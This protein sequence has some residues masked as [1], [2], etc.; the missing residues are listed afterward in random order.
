MRT[1]SGCSGNNAPTAHC[2]S[3]RVGGTNGFWTAGDLGVLSGNPCGGFQL[4]VLAMIQNRLTVVLLPFLLIGLGGCTGSEESKRLE[5]DRDVR[6]LVKS[7]QEN[8]LPT[9]TKYA[10]AFMLPVTQDDITRDYGTRYGFVMPIHIAVR[11]GRIEMLKMLA[12][13]RRKSEAMVTFDVDARD[14]GGNTPIMKAHFGPAKKLDECVRF[15]VAEGADVN[16]RNA[17]LQYTAL[18]DAAQHTLL[19]YAELLIGLGANVNLQDTLGR[20]PMHIICG[21]EHGITA[22]REAV[23][24]VFLKAKPDLSLKDKEGRT[25]EQVAEKL[26]YHAY[27]VKLKG[28]ARGAKK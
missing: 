10:R 4:E 16:A 24:D 15:L 9:A 12:E 18:H 28:A 20:T 21:M 27:V 11:H 5:R 19:G 3:L 25:A 6:T 7:I 14:S 1:V 17:N 23:F 13:K 8:D 26:G 22:E 2:H